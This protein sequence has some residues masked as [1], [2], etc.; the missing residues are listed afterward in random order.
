MAASNG[1]LN[2]HNLKELIKQGNLTALEEI[3][4]QGNGDKL[5]GETSTAPIVQEFLDNL[6]SYLVRSNRIYS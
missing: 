1:T 5:L 3:V 6:P 2:R 4:L